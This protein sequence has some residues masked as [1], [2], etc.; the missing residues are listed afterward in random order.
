MRQLLQDAARETETLAHLLD[1]LLELSR[2]QAD[3]LFLH[4]EPV[5]IR[6]VIRGVVDRLGRQTSQHRFIMEVTGDIPAAQA[7]RIRLGRI[8]YNLAENAVKYSPEGGSIMITASRS[9]SDLLVSVADHG[10][11]INE[12]DQ[13]K[14]FAPFQRLESSVTGRTGGAGLGLLVCRRLVEAQG[15]T[16]WVESTPGEGST[17]HFTLPGAD[18]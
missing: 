4:L 11:G 8:V 5:D 1:N 12:A 2:A 18:D 17:F 9:G 3:R 6:S 10:L 15:G 13:Q 16:I 14:L 7:D